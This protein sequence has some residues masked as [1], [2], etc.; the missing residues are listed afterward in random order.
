MTTTLQEKQEKIN[1]IS[2]P[3]V[4]KLV[5]NITANPG[6][7]LTHWGATTRWI[8]GTLS[9]TEISS[10]CIGTKEVPRSFRFRVDEPTEL[11]G[12]NKYPN[13]QEYLLG[14]LNAC[15]VVG[16]V[17]AATHL[18]VELES[19][20]IESQGNIDLRGFLG[21]GKD[22]KPGYDEIHY[23]VRVKGKGT[24]E[25]F[26]QIH[27]IVKATSPNRFNLSQPIKLSS[28]LIVDGTLVS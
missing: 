25:Q 14:A 7:A 2:L 3:A 12:A 9:E 13:P 17:A 27:E 19:L 5:A 24:E 26:K 28:D 21:I 4:Q 1:G 8:A 10:F 11:A 16:Y 15:M 22:V 20:E 6:E 18:G 23:T